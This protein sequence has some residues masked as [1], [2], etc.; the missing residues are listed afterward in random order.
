MNADKHRYE[1]DF[2]GLDDEQDK[3]IAPRQKRKASAFI[4]VHLWLLLLVAS[5]AIAQVR[6]VNDYGAMGLGQLLKRLQTTG[7]VMMIGAHPDDE[8]SALLAYLARGESARTAYLSLTRGDGGQNIIGPELFEALGVIRT[9]ELLQARRL[10]GAEQYFT[11]AYDYGFS[12]TLAEA[13]SKWPENVIKCDVVHAIRLFRPL[14]VISRFTGTPQDGH[15]QHQ[16]SGWITPIAVKAAADPQQCTSEGEPWQVRKFYIESGFQDN[17]EPTLKINTGQ[18]DPILGRTYFEIAMEGRSLHRSQ[19]EGRIEFHGDSFSGLNL[20][21]AA[22]DLREKDIFQGLDLSG[23]PRGSNT[24]LVPDMADPQRRILPDLV[25][26]YNDLDQK[27]TATELRPVV[28]SAILRAAG[29]EIDALSDREMVVPGDELMVAVKAFLP[30]PSALQVGEISMTVPEGWIVTRISAPTQ[31]NAAYNRREVAPAE[32][33]FNIK[34]PTTAELTQ[35]YWL[36]SE[37]KTDLFTWP[38]TGSRTFPFDPAQLIAHVKVTGLGLTDLALNQPVQY[39]FADPARGEI[40][41][42]INVV[43]PV[44]V[45]VA[46]RLLVVPVS[47]QEQTRQVDI[48]AT[49]NVCKPTQTDGTLTIRGN[50]PGWKAEAVSTAGDLAKCGDKAT[51]SFKLTVPANAKAGTYSFNAQIEGSGFSYGQTMNTVAYP[52]IQTHRYYTPAVTDVLV[53]DLKTVP[54]NVGYI[55]GSGDEVPDAIRQ[56]GMNVTMLGEKDLASGDLSRF[57]T[58]VVGIRATETR[59]DFV[60]NNSR[61]LD[62]VKNG[63]NVI[64]Q[65]QRGNWTGIAP[66]PVNIQDKQGTTAGSINRVVDE[67]AKVTILDPADPVFNTPNKITDADFSGWVQERNAYNL[68][69]SDPQYKPLLESHD[70]GEQENKGGLVV[71]KVGKGTWMYCSYSFFRQ[72]PAGVPGAYRLFDNLL[73]LPKAR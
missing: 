3:A 32:A 41:R 17:S 16:Y 38:R 64:V 45:A 68:V 13:K 30:N 10:D 6:P 50:S 55:M 66:Y 25:S 44:S 57:D 4:C 27:R 46:Q 61:L 35:P 22:K 26:A 59:P 33:V 69:T 42:E 67:N 5:T 54:V 58:I 71:A 47:G 8:D 48:V 11:R 37:R 43:P 51:E 24:L 9:E 40:R 62:Y 39:R 18:Y 36:T 34:V 72:L 65:Y 53:L 70:A 19:G 73:S 60:A 15:G 12:K 14:V 20:V 52:H 2:I 1:P 31:N 56:M 28:V 29:I 21:G 63:G 7:S 49:K 23:A